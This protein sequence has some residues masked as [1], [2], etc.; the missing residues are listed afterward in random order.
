MIVQ[1]VGWD[2]GGGRHGTGRGLYFSVENLTDVVNWG[3]DFALYVG[4]SYHQLRE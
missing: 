4:E 3:K 2:G 1:E